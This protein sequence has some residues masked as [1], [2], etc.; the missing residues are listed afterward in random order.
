MTDILTR[1]AA[2][3]VDASED[4]KGHP[5]NQCLI[6]LVR[7][8]AGEIERFRKEYLLMH[9]QYNSATEKLRQASKRVEELDPPAPGW[10]K[11]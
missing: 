4:W 3:T 11:D 2:L 6:A 9:E 5:R 7:E 1:L 8:A 10:G